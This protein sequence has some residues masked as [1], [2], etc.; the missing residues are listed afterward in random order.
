LIEKMRE[1]YDMVIVSRYLPPAKSADDSFITGF[2]NWFF[3]ALINL[4]HGASYTDSFVM[5][6]AYKTQMLLDLNLLK[7]EEYKT[8]EKLFRTKI[9]IEPL[10]SVRAARMKC[11]VTEIPGD[12]PARIGGERKLQVIRWGAGFLY[13]I[14]RETFPRRRLPNTTSVKSYSWKTDGI[15]V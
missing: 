11:R 14:I 2:G 12:E 8:P 1:G 15:E 3:T 6:R 9:P 13:Q 4:L 7:D 10:L 5:F